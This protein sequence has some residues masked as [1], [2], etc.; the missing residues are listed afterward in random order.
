M[1]FRVPEAD[2]F[3]ISECNHYL[4]EKLT[5]QDGL[6]LYA[7]WEFKRV[8]GGCASAAEAVETIKSRE[9]QFLEAESR[10]YGSRH[11]DR[12][13]PSEPVATPCAANG[14]ATG[15]SDASRP[16]SSP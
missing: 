11:R 16:V 12:S 9:A 13:L 10:L 1:K 7:V 14:S 5:T 2:K 6:T 8:M 4:I 15:N 3:R